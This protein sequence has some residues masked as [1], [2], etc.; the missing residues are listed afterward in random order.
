MAPAAPPPGTEDE[1]KVPPT[2]RADEDMSRDP[3]CAH[4]PCPCCWSEDHSSRWIRI[5]RLSPA[6]EEWSRGQFCGSRRCMRMGYETGAGSASRLAGS[7]LYKGEHD[8]GEVG[9]GHQGWGYRGRCYLGSVKQKA[10]VKQAYAK[11]IFGDVANLTQ[12]YFSCFN[13]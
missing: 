1:A 11:S 9:W 5:S 4:L 8:A 10:P 6:R 12:D 2:G 7:L 13:W 3:I